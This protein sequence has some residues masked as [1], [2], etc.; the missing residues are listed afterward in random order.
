VQY[1]SSGNGNAVYYSSDADNRITYREHDT[2]SGWDWNMNGQYWY[3]YTDDS[4]S[5]AFMYNSSGTIEE[6]YLTLPGGVS[7]STYNQHTVSSG[8]A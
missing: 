5:P 1:T 8:K 2:I 6:E 4:D 3:G 7:P